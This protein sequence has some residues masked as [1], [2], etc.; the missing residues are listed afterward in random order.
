VTGREREQ[1]AANSAKNQ[2]MF[3]LIAILL[4]RTTGHE[5]RVD[6]VVAFQEAVYHEVLAAIENARVGVP[7]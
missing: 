3:H 4:D 7:S 5:E 2:I 6:V 1:D